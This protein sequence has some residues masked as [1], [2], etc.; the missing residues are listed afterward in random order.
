MQEHLVFLQPDDREIKKMKIRPCLNTESGHTLYDPKKCVV[1]FA[2]AFHN[3]VERLRS[4]S[5]PKRQA[6]IQ[7]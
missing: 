6:F 7:Y 5:K 3:K 2:K 4:Q 1:Q